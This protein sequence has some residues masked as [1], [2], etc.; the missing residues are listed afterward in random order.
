MQVPKGPGMQA[1]SCLASMEAEACA[2]AGLSGPGGQQHPNIVGVIGHISHQLPLD[3]LADWDLGDHM[4][5]QQLWQSGCYRPTVTHL[6]LELCKG[7]SLASYI[8]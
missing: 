5:D 4:A 7:G 1:D 8:E 6:G 3:K 2:L